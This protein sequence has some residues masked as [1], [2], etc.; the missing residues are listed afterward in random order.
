M[1]LLVPYN[2]QNYT[3]PTT[4]E[5]GWGANL[6]AYLVAISSGSLQKSGGS[7]TLSAEVDFGASFGLKALYYKTRGSVIASTGN[8]R[9]E[10]A[11]TGVVWRNFANNAD[12]ALTVNASNQLTFN[13][14]AIGGSGIFTASRA[15]VSDG[16]GN[17]AVAT[18][19]AV[20]IGYVSG[21]TSA[22]QTQINA[23]KT[24]ATGNAYKFETTDVSGNL[25]ET[26]VTASKAVAT[27]ANGLPVASATTATELGYVNGVTSAIQTQL[28]SKEPTITTLGVNRGGTGDA[29]FTAYSVVCG[30]TTST[31]ALQS[32]ASLGSSGQVLTSNGAAA[33][34][35]WQNIAGG[36]TV[37]SGT[38]YQLAYYVASSNAV[39]GLTLITP[40]RAIASDANGLP[41]ASS[42]TAVELGYVSGVTSAIQTQ[43]GLKAP[44]ASPTFTGTVTI[45]DGAAVTS[46]AAIG[47]VNNA[48]GMGNILIN[49]DF[50]FWQRGGIA[51]AVST[52]SA[53]RWIS[54]VVAGGS[55]NWSFGLVTSNLDTTGPNVADLNIINAGNSSFRLYFQQ[56]VENFSNYLGKTITFTCRIKT[57]T[58]SL[59]IQL[60]DGV[61]TTTSSAHTGSGNYETLTVTKTVSASATELYVNIGFVDAQPSTT[62][63]SYFATAMLVLGSVAVP[64]VARQYGEELLL[65]QRYYEKSY[66]IGAVPGTSDA[67]LCIFTAAQIGTTTTRSLLYPFKATKRIVPTVSLFRQDGTSGSYA[68][69]S[70]AGASTNRA[71]SATNVTIVGFQIGQT[72]GTESY[73]E[74]HWV[75]DAEL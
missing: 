28:D 60:D 54:Q 36:G 34:P 57:S 24:I 49:G 73:A 7:F 75:A 18:T 30:G 65:C 2:G 19:T 69:I 68:W 55:P 12:L 42:V 66:A 51:N 70:V 59:K 26:T 47:Q 23:K 48:F 40:S 29:S 11:A 56:R 16:S 32:V 20:E 3:I 62:G 8:F 4:G 15:I 10:N 52:Y 44:L 25:Q 43:L 9:L 71:T 50:T 72:A 21:V 6:D 37:N 5:V 45:P 31:G 27:D 35:T 17:L 1:S 53:D 14:V 46:A 61:T 39:S 13:G 41:V 74:G 67:N 38:Q 63:H 58:T 33:L 64:F 22:I